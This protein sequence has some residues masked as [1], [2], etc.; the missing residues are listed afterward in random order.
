MPKTS[1][2][3]SSKRA[4]TLALLSAISACAPAQVTPNLRHI[5]SRSAQTEDL[6]RNP[7]I[8]IPGILGSRLKDVEHEVLAW[9]AFGS[10]S[11]DPSAPEGMRTVALPMEQGLPLSQ[12]RDSVTS[13]GVLSKLRIEFLGIPLELN[14]YRQILATL[15]VGGYRDQ[16]LA[17]NGH[18]DYGTE[19]F[20][21]F[22]HAYD[23]R[24]DI[25][26]NALLLHEFISA[27]R[28]YI[29]REFERRFG[30]K[31]HPV[32]FDIV[33]HSMGGL[34]ARY[35]L[36][37]GPTPLP[38]DDTLPE[39]NWAGAKHI[40]RVILI[41]T[42]NAG[43][44]QAFRELVEGVKFSPFLPKYEAAVLGT[45]PSIY[46]LLPRSRHRTIVDVSDPEQPLNLYDPEEW[47]RR[48]WG[49]A[50]PSQA[51]VLEALL[52]DVKDSADRRELAIDHLRKCLQRAEQLSRALD[53]PAASPAGLSLHLI[54]GDA[55]PTASVIAV[56]GSSKELQVLMH[57]AG[58]GVVLRSSALLDERV[59]RAWTRTLQ[60]P[61]PWD[62]VTFIFRD[63]LALTQ[64]P[65]FTDNILYLLLEKPRLEP[66][67]G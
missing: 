49:L 40:E 60:S 50:D 53:R 29:Q 58:D 18:V 66:G 33:A 41:G 64:D 11:I 20:S 5:Y 35:Y 36:M 31:D 39:L 65:A 10:G 32:K 46:Q 61:I 62:H 48:N 45:M 28:A 15:G 42:P 34:V 51:S 1:V 26:E 12:L 63:H 9:G 27:K 21:C 30:A 17:E 2:R 67:L 22:Q 56:R 4:L 52:P 38:E 13:D 14:A 6:H 25:S 54:A 59:G 16:D 37:Y 7:V 43:S 8:V 57:D 55:E 23:W 19:H 47:I 44:A 3:W 24:R